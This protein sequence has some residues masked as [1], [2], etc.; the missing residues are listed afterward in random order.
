NPRLDTRF[1]PG[2]NPLRV[3]I[4]RKLQLPNHLHLFDKSLPTV[5]Y[6][7]KEQKQSHENLAYV[8]LQEGESL[9]G[10]IMQDLHQRKVL[11]L[12]VE[13]GT[14]LLKSLLK[15]N[16]WDEAICFKSQNCVL[17]DGTPAPGMVH[18]QLMEMQMAGA[19]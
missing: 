1:W 16:L 4:D 13:G 18:S 15:E 3:V 19:D 11:S 7:Y 2:H 5:V 10:Q 14:Y 12:L 9:L 17:R 6:T 8:Q